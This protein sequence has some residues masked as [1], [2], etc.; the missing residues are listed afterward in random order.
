MIE[1][2]LRPPIWALD[3]GLP[4]PLPGESFCDYWTRLGVPAA[5]IGEALR[6]LNRAAAQ[7]ANQRMD[8]YV[9]KVC[10]DTFALV[11]S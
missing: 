5:A 2:I 3:A 11:S 1:P 6:G 8:L 7:V 10:P 4:E 9:R